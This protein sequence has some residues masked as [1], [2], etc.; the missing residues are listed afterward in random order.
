MEPLLW[1]GNPVHELDSLDASVLQAIHHATPANWEPFMRGITALGSLEFLGGLVLALVTILAWRRQWQRAGFLA[2]SG[3]LTLILAKALKELFQRPRP[4]LWATIA[5]DSYSFP[6]G[7]ALRAVVIYGVLV[8]W[9]AQSRPHWRPL[10]WGFY[11]VLVVAIGFSR[12][13]LGL[14]W[15]TDVLGSWVLGAIALFGLIYWEKTLYQ[16]FGALWNRLTG[17]VGNSWKP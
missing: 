17:R 8:Y 9:L 13:Y 11:S 10:L 2:A 4:E 16:L 5:E 7:H 14:H 3:L 6:S 12:L 15:S 1:V